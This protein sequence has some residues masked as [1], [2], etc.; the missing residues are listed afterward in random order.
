MEKISL[1]VRTENNYIAT[2][3]I[4]ACYKFLIMKALK[5]INN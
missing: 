1:N 3:Q 5:E 2:S 4:L